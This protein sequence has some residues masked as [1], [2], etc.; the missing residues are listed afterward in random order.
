MQHEI[1]K[2][3][4]FES[5]TWNIIY[6]KTQINAVD[7]QQIFS[8]KLNIKTV[9]MIFKL[10]VF[11]K[12]SYHIKKLLLNRKCIYV[13]TTNADDVNDQ[14]MQRLTL[15]WYRRVSEVTFKSELWWLR[16]CILSIYF[17]WLWRPRLG[18]Q[19]HISRCL[20][21]YVMKNTKFAR[22][23]KKDLKRIV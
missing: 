7:V 3:K 10:L 6:K 17:L 16:F 13:F 22:F 2:N 23:A 4:K 12:I 14:S 18:I 11:S 8:E 5:L 1:F 9:K 15:I 21:F 20:F 19:N